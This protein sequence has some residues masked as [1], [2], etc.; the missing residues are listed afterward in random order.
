MDER[1]TKEQLWKLIGEDLKRTEDFLLLYSLEALKEYE[2]N[3]EGYRESL[4]SLSRSMERHIY[5]ETNDKEIT[6][7][8]TDGTH[9]E[10]WGYRL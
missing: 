7:E 4:W 6:N 2:E 9:E 8:Y 1:C 5:R 10:V 3:A